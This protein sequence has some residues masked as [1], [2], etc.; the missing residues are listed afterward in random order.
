[1]V[2]PAKSAGIP[3]GVSSEPKAYCFPP[4]HR[5]AASV[6]PAKGLYATAN[7]FTF[8]YNIVYIRFWLPRLC[9]AGMS[10]RYQ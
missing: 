6:A 3:S 1:M 8:K 5:A 7:P 9:L 10:I 4:K 2:A